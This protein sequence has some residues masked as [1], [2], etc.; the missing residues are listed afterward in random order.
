MK[1]NEDYSKKWED[2]QCSWIGK[3]S[4]LIIKMAILLKI[5]N[6]FNASLS[7]HPRIF[8]TELVEIILNFIQNLFKLPKQSQKKEQCQRYNSPRLQTILQSYS[9]QHSTVLQ[10]QQNNCSGTDTQNNGTKSPEI[11]TCTH[12]VSQSMTKETGY[13][14]AKR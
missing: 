1:E 9:N 14:M 11:N 3:K 4:T 10:K 6:R 7:K 13:I 12:T 2:V 8:F 5:T